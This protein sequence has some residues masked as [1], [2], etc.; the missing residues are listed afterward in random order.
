MMCGLQGS[1]KTATA[2]LAYFC[3]RKTTLQNPR[4]VLAYL[5]S[6][7]VQQLVTLAKSIQVDF[8][9]KG[10]NESAQN[11]V[12]QAIENCAN[13]NKNDL[14]IIDTAGRLSIDKALM[15]ELVDLK[16]IAKPRNIFVGGALSGQ[17]IINVAST[18][19]EKLKLS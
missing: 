5:S 15:N 6:S 17:D 16:H 9:E 19:N 2:K 11:I 12:S 1:S 13:E 7:A 10:I 8:F 14:I 18:F 3:A 4:T